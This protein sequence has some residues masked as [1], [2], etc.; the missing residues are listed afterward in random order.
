M[1]GRC[2][3]LDWM[4]RELVSD[5]GPVAAAH[6]M[7][8]LECKYPIRIFFHYIEMANALHLY[9][10]QILDV[11]FPQK[12]WLWVRQLSGVETICEGVS[13]SWS[14]ILFF[15]AELGLTTLHK[16]QINIFSL[17]VFNE[18]KIYTKIFITVKNIAK[19]SIN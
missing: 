3:N 13:H 9:L 5:A 7:G 1:E 19:V 18:N 17:I 8:S 16:P 12:W 14:N 15:K 4:K 10:H 2:E 11:S 6:L